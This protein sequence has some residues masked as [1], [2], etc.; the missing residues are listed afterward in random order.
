VTALCVFTA[1]IGYSGF[2][3]LD[4]TRKSAGPEGLP[5]AP[6]WQILAPVLAMR[7][8]R[9]QRAARSAWPRYV[10]DYTAEMRRSYREHRAVWDKLLARDEV[11]LVCYCPD[12]MFC[13]R[14]L[15]ASILMAC[16]AKYAGERRP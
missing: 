6:S 12:P 3:R 9:G 2:D 13:H 15:L 5:F 1:R 8:R 4:V 16:G 14:T 10:V 7:R 11:T